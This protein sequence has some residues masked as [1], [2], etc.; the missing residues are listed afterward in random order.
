MKTYKDN[1][2]PLRRAIAKQSAEWLESNCPEVF[3]ALEQ[4]LLNGLSVGDIRRVLRRMFGDDLRDAF[5]L[6]VIQ[7]AE[8]IQNEQRK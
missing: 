5:V 8:H 7:A 3:D 6:R 1:E 4:E 2:R